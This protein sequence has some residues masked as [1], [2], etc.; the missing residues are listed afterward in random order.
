MLI[1]IKQGS[2]ASKVDKIKEIIKCI[3]SQSELYSNS[4]KVNLFDNFY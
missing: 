4:K 3:S 2:R 1:K